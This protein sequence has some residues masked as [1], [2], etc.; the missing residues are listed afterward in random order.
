MTC[1]ATGSFNDGSTDRPLLAVSQDA[2]TSWIYP[3]SI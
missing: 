1:I 2:G 3:A